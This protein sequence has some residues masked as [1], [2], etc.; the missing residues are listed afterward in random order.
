M[1]ENILFKLDK[2]Q[3]I[4]LIK[5]LQKL[6]ESPSQLKTDEEDVDFGGVW[7][8]IYGLE[9]C[10]ID[11]MPIL[12]FKPKD[13]KRYYSA[14]WNFPRIEIMRK[15]TRMDWWKKGSTIRYVIS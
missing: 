15:A 13:K 11:I 10:V 7:V 1:T 12:K 6:L 2:K 4:R 5:Y 8:K 9:N 14:Y 3:V